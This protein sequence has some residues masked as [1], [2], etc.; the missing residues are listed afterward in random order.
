M[1]QRHRFLA[2]ILRFSL[3]PIILQ[4]ISEMEKINRTP[5]NELW[6]ED[7]A[8]FSDMESAY[9]SEAESVFFRTLHMKMLYEYAPCGELLLSPRSNSDGI[10]FHREEYDEFIIGHLLPDGSYDDDF[11]VMKLSDALNANLKMIGYLDK[12]VTFL[13]WLRERSYRDLEYNHNQ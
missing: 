1:D 8:L 7:E 4:L 3:F 11:H 2:S 6:P 12:D 5:E 10:G 9:T 13:Q